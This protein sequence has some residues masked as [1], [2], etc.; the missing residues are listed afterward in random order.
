MAETTPICVEEYNNRFF[1]CT[2]LTGIELT[3][4]VTEI[5]EY[6]FS[7][8]ALKN[9]EIPLGSME[10]I[11]VIKK[12]S[13]IE[14][15]FVAAGGIITTSQAVTAYNNGSDMLVCPVFLK[16]IV[17]LSE[18][19]KIPVITTVSTANEAYR[20]WK[21]RVPISKLYPATHL[22]GTEYVYDLLRPMPFLNLMAT[23][24]IKIKEI[25]DYIKV[26]AIAVGIG[27]DLYKGLS[28]E[29][30][31]KKATEAI[32]IIKKGA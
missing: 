6:A 23:G 15:V 13:Q 32:E 5:G 11:D 29:E 25:N 9:I 12:L 31:T 27:S 28:P 22:G 16:N 14:G 30:I 19:F 24:G 18:E 20:S 8:T 21:A 10:L 17:K 4:S 2:S 1:G 7:G 26:G 3:N